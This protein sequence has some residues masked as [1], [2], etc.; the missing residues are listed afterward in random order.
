LSN[1]T[2][3]HAAEKLLAGMEGKGTLPFFMYT[4]CSLFSDI[5]KAMSLAYPCHHFHHINNL[6]D[7]SIH[8]FDNLRDKFIHFL[9]I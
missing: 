9:I 5:V 1:L 7:K 4:S 2:A 3:F 8:F 6:S